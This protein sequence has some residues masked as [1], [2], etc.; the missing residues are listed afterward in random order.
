MAVSFDKTIPILR[1]FDVPKAKEFYSDFLG[2]AVDWE[3]HFDDNSPAYMQ[4]SRGD[5]LDRKSVV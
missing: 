3:H 1:I 4:L 2:F 5:L